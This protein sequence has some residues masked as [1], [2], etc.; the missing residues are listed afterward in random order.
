MDLYREVV[1]EELQRR[2]GL[3]AP[4]SE[5]LEGKSGTVHVSFGAGIKG[6]ESLR[7]AQ[8]QCQ[9][10]QELWKDQITVGI[11]TSGAERFSISLTL[12]L[13]RKK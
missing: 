6:L 12:S 10:L 4:L 8:Y 1:N 11:D 3:D 13:A 9:L 5:V 7:V 2:I